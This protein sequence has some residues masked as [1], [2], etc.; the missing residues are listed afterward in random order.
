[1]VTAQSAILLPVPVLARCLTFTL[2]PGVDPGAE[3]QAWC[4]PVD[5]ET[6]GRGARR[7]ARL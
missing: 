1:M 4:R 3:M 5:G 6:R 2:K 7:F